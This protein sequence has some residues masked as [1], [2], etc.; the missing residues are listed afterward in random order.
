[1]NQRFDIVISGA[2]YTGAALALALSKSLEGSLSI[3]VIDKA[4]P[5]T[6]A[7]APASPRAFSVSAA[8]RHLLEYLG[9]WPEIAL[10][11]Q[12][13]SEIEITDSPLNAGI[14][15]VL[16]TYENAIDDGSPASHIVPDAILAN[17]LRGALTLAPGVEVFSNAAVT[18]FA[19]GGSAATVTCSHGL[20][21]VADLVVAAEGRRS[22][23]REAAAIK[24][25]GWDYS[26][27]GICTLIQHSRPH[28]GRAVQ[29]FLPSGPFAILPLP[30]QRSCITWTEEKSEARRIISL[31]DPEFLAEVEQRFSGRLGELELVMRPSS[32]PLSLHLAR[33]FVGPRVALLGDTA[34]GVH[35]IAGQGLNLGFRDVAALTEVIVEN[36]RIGLP[37]SDPEGLKRYER[38]RRFDSAVSTAAFDGLNRLFSNDNPLLR[39]IREAGL[40]LVDRLPLA[41]SLL[42]KEA[43]GLTGDVPR[44]LRGEPL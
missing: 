19:V 6:R 38:W 28:E 15:P 37:A 42:V 9:V 25:V 11:S 31:S 21:L 29:H 27:S 13:V 43:A 8:S 36:A 26:Q 7:T 10:S 30:G 18:A 17:A 12:P 1:M 5:G 44:L 34:R 33:S 32:W 20:E 14:R 3:A 4:P 40:G 2:S 41:K 35:P 24:T 23:I 39:S 16:L 22:A